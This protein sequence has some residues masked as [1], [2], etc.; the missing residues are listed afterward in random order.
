MFDSFKHSS[1][2]FF[3]IHESLC[4]N[5]GQPKLTITSGLTKE[6]FSPTIPPVNGE[7][8]AGAVTTGQ[9]RQE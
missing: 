6:Q 2:N 1:Y 4:Y 7:P 3:F 9:E 5:K 8:L